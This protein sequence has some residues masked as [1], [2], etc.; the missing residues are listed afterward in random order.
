MLHVGLHLQL[1]TINE[2][3]EFHTFKEEE[4]LRL[5]LLVFPPTHQTLYEL[6]HSFCTVTLQSFFFF[7]YPQIL[8]WVG[9]E[10]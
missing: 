1:L 10:N 3:I 4:R 8:A 5:V 2:R 9:Q 6:I 7:F